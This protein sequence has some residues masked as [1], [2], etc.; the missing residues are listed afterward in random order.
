MD[1]PSSQDDE[2]IDQT[3]EYYSQRTG[4]RYRPA[5]SYSS[6]R[7]YYYSDEHPEVPKVRRASLGVDEADAQTTSPRKSARSPKDAARRPS[8]EKV[9]R[10]E[11]TPHRPSSPSMQGGTR[12][13][14][15]AR[16]RNNRSKQAYSHPS[17]YHHKVS[18]YDEDLLGAFEEHTGQ[19]D[20][21][22]RTATKIMVAQ[23]H[24][25]TISTVY[26]PPSRPSAY[27]PKG[28]RTKQ[29]NTFLA[30]LH[31]LG[32]NRRLMVVISVF[33]IL[34]LV[35]PMVVNSIVNN[36]H[37]VT[38]LPSG[39]GSAIT[40]NT[41]G[42]GQATTRSS[43]SNP[44]VLTITPMDTDHPAPPVFA[45]SA[46]LLDADTGATLY[47]HNPFMH[48]PMLSTTKLMT[49]LLAVEKGNPN[50][51]ITINNKISN[52][53]NQ[54]AADSSVMGIKKGETYTLREL[55][56]GMF[57]VSG[58]DAATAVADAIGGNLP[59]FVNMMNQRAAQLGLYNTHYMNPHGLLEDGHYSSAHDLAILGAA[60]M[61][62]PL[63]HQISAT[64]H[65][66]LPKTAQHAEHVM[67]NGDQFLWWYPG[68][69]G[70]KPGWDGDSN[71]IQVV[72]VTRN[73]HHLIGVTM[74]T[75]DWWTDMRD[76]M[77]WGFD[78]FQWVS[79]R[80]SDQASPIPYDSDWDY[81]AKDTPTVTIPTADSGRYYVYTGYSIAGIILTY[82]DKN[83]GLK[84]F[85]YPESLPEATETTT[86]SQR[87]DH[88]TL[89]CDTV[90][91]QCKDL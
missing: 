19:T 66:T 32:H 25:S 52:D 61:K 84:K 13:A 88:G 17:S 11:R 79:P 90:T 68:V 80:I 63:L 28:R 65:Y 60:V 1:T 2:I 42:N 58:N 59:T 87:F 18:R 89:Q 74:H 85:G 57:L 53:I 6:S 36:N 77:N 8:T 21:A 31:H 81:F 86:V 14:P 37:S 7:S 54:L 12:P 4:P 69:D 70:G 29:Q 34:L 43:S 67:F 33:I 72:S 45:T 51:E 10:V 3:S 35:S 24:R 75:S 49:A 73:G 38:L 15:S 47:A 39:S 71:F 44:N 41:S 83:G 16:A 82:F 50:Q 22:P 40:V 23:R 56:Y 5:R 91:R 55:L 46:Y 48:L 9:A 20:A 76:L 27:R 78:S 62:V 26:E 64:K 30:Y